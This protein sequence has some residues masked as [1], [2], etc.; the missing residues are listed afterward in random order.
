M[1]SV[2]SDY[3]DDELLFYLE[4]AI[5]SEDVPTMRSVMA[6]GVDVNAI[7]QDDN[8]PLCFAALDGSTETVRCLLEEGHA[9]TNMKDA[10]GQTPLHRACQVNWENVAGK[11]EKIRLL[12]QHHA[13]INARNARGCTPLLYLCSL[14]RGS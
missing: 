3:D 6:A 5:L 1:S 9:D 4:V 13:D 2:D 7:S 10:F 11:Q 12:L 8:T 14:A